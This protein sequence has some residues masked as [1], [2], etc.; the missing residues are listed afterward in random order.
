MDGTSSKYWKQIYICLLSVS[1]AFLHIGCQASAKIVKGDAPEI[2]FEKTTHDF[3]IVR[4]VERYECE[5]KF[6]NVGNAL[7]E[8]NGIVKTCG[9]SAY[10]L[11]KKEYEP[12]ESGVLKVWFNASGNKIQKT[13]YLLGVYSNAKTN[14]YVKLTLN[15][16]IAPQE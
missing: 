4:P 8:I 14:P 3:G 5:F 12:G 10:G 2:V 6:K 7:L 1:L 11:E 13:R 16:H 15:A 9:C